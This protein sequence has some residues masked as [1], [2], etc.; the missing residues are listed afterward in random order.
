MQ[1][2][3]YVVNCKKEICEEFC[4]KRFKL[5]QLYDK[6]LLSEKQKYRKELRLDENKIDLVAY[7]TLK[8]IEQHIGE[9]VGKG[10]NLYIYSTTC[11]NGKTEWS[12]RLIQAY[13]NNIWYCADLTC[14]ALFISVPKFLLALKRNISETDDY[15]NHIISNVQDADIVVWDD[16]ATKG[17]TEFEIENLLSIIDSRI[18]CGKTNIFTS[19]LTPKDLVSR[20]GDRL[21]SRIIG[22]STVVEF[23]GADKRGL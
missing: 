22:L 13:L 23:K 17:G 18:D 4:I 11:G 2:D 3:C 5:D 15:A 12:V 1:R 7:Q 9:F 19:N 8:Q 21:A 10:N 6:S 16:I 14:H 20:V